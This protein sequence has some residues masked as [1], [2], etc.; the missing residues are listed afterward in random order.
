MNDSAAKEELRL[1]LLTAEQVLQ[2]AEE[3]YVQYL[4]QLD[5]YRRTIE[6]QKKVISAIRLRLHGPIQ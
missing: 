3:E 1:K 2:K 6:E 5:L 4:Q